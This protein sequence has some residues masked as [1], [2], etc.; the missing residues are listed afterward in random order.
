MGSGPAIS[1][2]SEQQSVNPGITLVQKNIVQSLENEGHVSLE[3]S[4]LL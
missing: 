4:G 2:P 3:G 1:S